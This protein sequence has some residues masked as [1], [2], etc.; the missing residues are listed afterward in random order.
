MCKNKQT[1]NVFHLQAEIWKHIYRE[2]ILTCNKLFLLFFVTILKY[3]N[4][5]LHKLL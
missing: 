3:Y 1:E 5:Q 4:K 2:E